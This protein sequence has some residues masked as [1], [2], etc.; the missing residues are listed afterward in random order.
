[1]SA[2]SAPMP[3]SSSSGSM[4]TS[5]RY[6]G[7][8][9]SRPTRTDAGTGSPET[10]LAGATVCRSRRP[11]PPWARAARRRSRQGRRG[12]GRRRAGPRPP[13][14]RRRGRAWPKTES[15]GRA[16]GSGRLPTVVERLRT[17]SGGGFAPVPG[18]TST[19]TGEKSAPNGTVSVAYATIVAGARAQ[20]S[21]TRPVI[22]PFPTSTT[23]LSTR[24]PARVWRRK[25]PENRAAGTAVS[26]RR[27]STVWP[28]APP[29]R[30][31]CAPLVT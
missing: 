9:S 28:A 30:R 24:L 7:S 15:T 13:A 17:P 21:A 18:S 16:A 27:P 3:G 5:R 26:A 12:R 25:A 29:R 23:A 1:M 6:S 10:V 2:G 14:Q 19:T 20:L 11:A 4:A 8:V 22:A 31:A